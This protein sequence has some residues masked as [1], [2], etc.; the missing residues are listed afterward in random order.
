MSQQWNE[1]AEKGESFGYGC[2]TRGSRNGLWL[3]QD[4]SAAPKTKGKR[5][6]GDWARSFSFC[7]LKEVDR[8]TPALPLLETQQSGVTECDVEGKQ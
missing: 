2:A 4:R 5:V 8:K 3:S 6:E 1:L 7:I